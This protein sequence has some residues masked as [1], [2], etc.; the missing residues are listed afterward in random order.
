MY[1]SGILKHR[2]DIWAIARHNNL[3]HPIA[4]NPG[5]CLSW[6][7]RVQGYI[8]VSHPYTPFPK[9]SHHQELWLFRSAIMTLHCLTLLWNAKLLFCAID[10]HFKLARCIAHLDIKHICKDCTVWIG[11]QYHACCTPCIVPPRCLCMSTAV[12]V[13]R[14]DVRCRVCYNENDNWVKMWHWT[15]MSLMQ[16]HDSTLSYS[17][18]SR[19][20]GFLKPH[21]ELSYF[22][23]HQRITKL[24]FSA[25]SWVCSH[26]VFLQFMISI[27]HGKTFRIFLYFW[28]WQ[29]IVIF[30][31]TPFRFISSSHLLW[32][33]KALKAQKAQH[34]Q[35]KALLSSPFLAILASPQI[36]TKRAF[37]PSCMAESCKFHAVIIF[38]FNKLAQLTQ[39]F[40][41]TLAIE[42]SY[43]I[44]LLAVLLDLYRWRPEPK[45]MGNK[46]ST[47]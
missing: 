33:F 5:G 4:L 20:E 38:T 44:T 36:N 18:C 25:E 32:D 27:M 37:S 23:W 11:S 14:V 17:S 46:I 12:R 21:W 40:L 10:L 24:T 42:R 41:F 26:H 39:L 22:I 43:S 47:V 1:S 34:N 16:C 45:K 7:F 6:P 3:W 30:C 15:E 29:V 35:L 2:W 13:V 31:V 9:F 19:L 8:F 28:M